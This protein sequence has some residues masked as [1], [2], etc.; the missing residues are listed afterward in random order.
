M[1]AITKY[2]RQGSL[3]Q[4]FFFS[5]FWRLESKS[6][7]SAGFVSSEP[8]LLD[9]WRTDI[10][11]CLHM[12]FLLCKSL[13]SVYSCIPISSY[14]TP[15]RMEQSTQGAHFNLIFISLGSHLQNSHILR[16]L[17]FTLQHINFEN[18][19]QHI[20]RG[21]PE[22]SNSSVKIQFYSLYVYQASI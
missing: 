22:C 15:V 2:Y 1:A 3:K 8:S 18:T 16:Y 5:Q 11:L 21:C 20:T 19:M 13:S 17:G 4:R 10:S 14:K 6:K 12:V 7:V 9:L